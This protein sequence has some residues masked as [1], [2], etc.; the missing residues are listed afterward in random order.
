MIPAPPPRATGWLPDP[1]HRFDQRFAVGGNWTRRVSVGGNEAIDVEA[2]DQTG[3]VVVR[4]WQT[5]PDGEWRSDA[6]GRFDE[7]W[8]DGGAWT[9]MIR[10]GGHIATDCL[11]APLVKRSRK[12]RR[13]DADDGPGWRTDPD[14]DGQRYW[15]GYGWTGKHRAGPPVASSNLQ[16]WWSRQLLIGLFVL[17][18]LLVLVA[19]GVVVVVF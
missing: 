15:D 13:H 16:G 7:R 5:V 11:A 2:L 4:P 6:A 19:I 17:I 18:A 12:D 9:R 14:G 8:W 10:T 1:T 3:P